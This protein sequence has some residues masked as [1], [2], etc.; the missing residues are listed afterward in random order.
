[1]RILNHAKPFTASVLLAFVTVI[2]ASACGGSSTTGQT[3]DSTT[4]E[5]TKAASSTDWDA[6]GQAIGKDGKVMK[7]DVYRVDLPRSD[8]QVTADGVQIKPALSLGSYTAFKD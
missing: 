8:L 4:Q 2:G 6:V 7:G 1:M 3:Q 5:Q